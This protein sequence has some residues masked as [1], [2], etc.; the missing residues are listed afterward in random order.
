MEFSPSVQEHLQKLI[1]SGVIKLDRFQLERDAPE[2]IEA[3]HT[4]VVVRG[5]V[6]PPSSVPFCPTQQWAEQD[7]DSSR[8]AHPEDV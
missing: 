4:N 7:P 1:A 5:C 3:T 8:E 6:S 2:Y